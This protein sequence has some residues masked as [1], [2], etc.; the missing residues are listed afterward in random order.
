VAPHA[1]IATMGDVD[2][3]RKTDKAVSPA[4]LSKHYCTIGP[5]EE[6]GVQQSLAAPLDFSEHKTF[7]QHV[8]PRKQKWQ[9]RRRMMMT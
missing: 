3:Q 5:K 9:L 4:N 2:V 8:L 7:G 1:F 6:L